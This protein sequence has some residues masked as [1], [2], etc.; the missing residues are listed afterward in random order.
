MPEWAA[1]TFDPERNWLSINLEW[2]GF[3]RLHVGWPDAI[4]ATLTNQV[5]NY[6][7]GRH[8]VRLVERV[9]LHENDAAE[10]PN[11]Y[12]PNLSD[13]ALTVAGHWSETEIR[14]ARRVVNQ[15]LATRQVPEV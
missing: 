6:L 7:A 9:L 1:A 15:F 14:D 10:R 2:D 13:D 5:H 8:A 11:G 12:H 4:P 3:V